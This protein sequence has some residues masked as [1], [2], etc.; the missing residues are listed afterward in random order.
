MAAVAFQGRPRPQSRQYQTSARGDRALV[1]V[2]VI[3]LYEANPNTFV[4]STN[5]GGVGAGLQEQHHSRFAVVGRREAS[6]NQR[7]FLKRAPVVV[8]GEQDAVPVVHF[9]HW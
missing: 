6:L 5:D 3:N 4:L 8:L 2:E 7:L 9:Q 1:R